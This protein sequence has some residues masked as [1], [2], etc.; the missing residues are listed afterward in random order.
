[1][2]HYDRA[3]KIF[4]KRAYFFSFKKTIMF[5]QKITHLLVIFCCGL[6]L[7]SCEL[8]PN[9]ESLEQHHIQKI[10]QSSAKEGITTI[11]NQATPPKH[12]TLLLP[13]SDKLSASGQAIRNGFLTA[14]YYAKQHGQP[15]PEMDFIDTTQGNLQNL[16]QKAVASGAD[17]IVGPLTKSEVTTFMSGNPPLVPILAL[18]T[19]DNY[20]DHP[21]NNLYQFGLAPQDEA[22]QI[23]NKIIR[24]G[25]KKVLVIAPASTWGANLVSVFKSNLTH[26]GGTIVD[27]LNYDKQTDFSSEISSLLKV[28][29]TQT[30]QTS[31]QIK[32]SD[33]ASY[34]RQDFDAIFIIAKPEEARQINPLLKFYYAGDIPAY[35]T[36]LIYSGTPN[37]Q[38]DF[39]LDGIIFC[40]LPWVLRNSNELP[41]Y[42]QATQQ[43]ITSTLPGYTIATSKLYALGIDSYNLMRFLN[44]KGLFPKQG[45]IGATGTLFLTPSNHIYR[46]LEWVKMQDGKPAN[47][48]EF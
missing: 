36:S 25:H 28:N 41:Q 45:L 15:I 35:A 30:K 40:D 23:A 39:D 20:L 12:V 13:L 37:S 38:L 18:N 5:S 32:K 44:Q 2:I 6:L 29:K 9:R 16:Y 19:V 47:L 34:R 26:L 43:Q 33:L 10:S 31:S 21:L 17:F 48:S 8:V 11:F 46:R 1:M 14:H 22:I 24:D 42:L 27:Q 7:T 3:V 4:Q